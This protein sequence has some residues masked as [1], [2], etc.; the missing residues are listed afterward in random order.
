MA[1]DGSAHPD[2]PLCEADRFTHW[3]ATSSDG[4]VADCE[5]CLVPMVVAWGHGEEPPAVMTER[6]LALLSQVGD[7]R[8]GPDRWRLDPVMRQVPGHFHAHCRPTSPTDVPTR[9]SRYTGVGTD[10]VERPGVGG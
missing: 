5:S 9:L 2:C 3:Y 1:D 7:E 4:W 10:R 8:F 6:L